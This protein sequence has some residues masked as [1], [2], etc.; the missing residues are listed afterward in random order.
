MSENPLFNPPPEVQIVSQFRA[1]SDAKP[2]IIGGQCPFGEATAFE[3]VLGLPHIPISWISTEW[4]VD[5]SY[6]IEIWIDMKTKKNFGSWC[7]NAL[8]DLKCRNLNTQ[9]WHNLILI[10]YT[11]FQKDEKNSKIE[12]YQ[13]FGGAKAHPNPIAPPSLYNKLSK[14]DKPEF[15]N[16][17]QTS[18]RTQCSTSV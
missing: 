17:K 15:A 10:T 2:F 4:I 5:F 12:I 13:D 16:S 14:Y 3:C 8:E 1:F 18:V 7:T 9:K 6:K 11:E